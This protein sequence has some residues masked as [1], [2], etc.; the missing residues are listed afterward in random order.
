MPNRYVA[1]SLMRLEKAIHVMASDDERDTPANFRL[2]PS[3]NVIDFQSLRI[4]ITLT[5]TLTTR[6]ISHLCCTLGVSCFFKGNQGRTLR[7]KLAATVNVLAII[8]RHR[9]NEPQRLASL[10]WRYRYSIHRRAILLARGEKPLT[11]IKL[12]ARY[13]W[14]CLQFTIQIHETWF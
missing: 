11:Q 5:L 14:L 3:N 7:T 12:I 1:L 2:C 10:G 8:C 6:R 4:R 9:A 13:R